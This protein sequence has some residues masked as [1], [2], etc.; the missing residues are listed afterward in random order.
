M[1]NLL[2][3]KRDSFVKIPVTEIIINF[4]GL[5]SLVVSLSQIDSG[6]LWFGVIL[7]CLAVWFSLTGYLICAAIRNRYT[8]D[9]LFADIVGIGLNEHMFN[10]MIVQNR[11]NKVLTVYDELWD[12]WLFPYKKALTQEEGTEADLSEISAVRDYFSTIAEVDRN[13]IKCNLTYQEYTDKC[14]VSDKIQKIYYHRFFVITAEDLPDTD[15]FEVNGN[16]FR[17]WYISDLEVDQKTKKHNA[18]IVATVKNKVL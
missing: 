12:M 8:H 14:S 10:L 6:S 16:K 7:F 18:E 15:E 2:E 11:Q 17:W 1:Q 3:K 5:L 13:K 9:Q 4:I